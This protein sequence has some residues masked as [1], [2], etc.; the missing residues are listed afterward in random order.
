MICQN[1]R[2]EFRQTLQI[3]DRLAQVAPEAMG[4]QHALHME[5]LA[6]FGLE[7]YDEAAAQLTA[8]IEKAPNFRQALILLGACLQQSQQH[9]KAL[10]HLEKAAAI[11]A[12]NSALKEMIEHSR[13][14]LAAAGSTQ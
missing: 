5:A 7:Q 10:Q 13:S 2:Q 9:A 14:Q 8:L 1:Q 6:L 4:N 3:R 12:P 11:E